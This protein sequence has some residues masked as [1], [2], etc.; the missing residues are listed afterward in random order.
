MARYSS[1]SALQQQDY[2]QLIT[3]AFVT[4]SFPGLQLGSASSPVAFSFGVE[5]RDI[6]SD[7]EHV[8]VALE[9]RAEARVAAGLQVA[10]DLMQYAFGRTQRATR[11]LG[12]GARQARRVA[13]GIRDMMDS[14]PLELG[15]Q[16]DPERDEQQPCRKDDGPRGKARPSLP[17]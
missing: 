6:G 4:G 13:L 7:A 16:P 2:E 8:G 3:S 15:E 9:D 1:A 14:R 10:S 5:H 11:M 12:I 17:K